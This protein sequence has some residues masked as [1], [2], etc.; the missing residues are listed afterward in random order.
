MGFN[1]GFKG[2]NNAASVACVEVYVFI[3]VAVAELVYNQP[4]G[5]QVTAYYVTHNYTI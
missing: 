4:D 2:L 3:S 1:S 5:H